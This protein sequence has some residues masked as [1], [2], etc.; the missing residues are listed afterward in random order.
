MSDGAGNKDVPGEKRIKKKN[1]KQRKPTTNWN[2]Q[3][4]ING[5]VSLWDERK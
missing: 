3:Y 4:S 5:E 1:D 2:I